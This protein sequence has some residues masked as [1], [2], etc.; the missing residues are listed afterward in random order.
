MTLNTFGILT[1]K[2]TEMGPRLFLIDPVCREAT[3]ELFAV[4]ATLIFARNAG[5][6]SHPDLGFYKTIT[7]SHHSDHFEIFWVRD[8]LKLENHRE[9]HGK[10]VEDVGLPTF[11]HE[12][13]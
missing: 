1:H 3:F 12:I 5:C 8:I 9:S 10:P 13:W 11:N 2:D 7:I 4:H 6:L